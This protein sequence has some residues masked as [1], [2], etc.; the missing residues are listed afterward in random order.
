MYS[1]GGQGAKFSRFS[2]KN[3][4][5]A[6]NM[7]RYPGDTEQARFCLSAKRVSVKSFVSLRM[8][9]LNKYKNIYSLHLICAIIRTVR[10][11]EKDLKG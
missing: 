3:G 5:M 6:A 7:V 1:E 11:I 9:V 10:L 2:E 4:L 8:G